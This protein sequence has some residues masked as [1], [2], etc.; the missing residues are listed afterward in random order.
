MSDGHV[1]LEESQQKE[2]IFKASIERSEEIYWIQD[3][4][5]N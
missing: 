1:V 3:G 4:D 2:Q 5:A